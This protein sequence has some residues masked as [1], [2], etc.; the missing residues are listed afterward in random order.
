MG[1][2]PRM[3]GSSVQ[4]SRPEQRIITL[5]PNAPAAA[6]VLL[7]K[8]RGRSATYCPPTSRAATISFGLPAPHQPHGDHHCRARFRI[9]DA[10]PALPPGTP[11]RCARHLHSLCRR[12]PAQASLLFLFMSAQSASGLL[13]IPS[14]HCHG[15][16]TT[17][18]TN[19]PN[20]TPT[21]TSW[22]QLQLARAAKGVLQGA[23]T[24]VP[25]RHARPASG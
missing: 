23:A 15:V 10:A 14:C 7:W 4:S 17:S 9:L 11:P 12:R 13:E 24:H 20:P 1:M 2:S 21:P 25:R 3:L 16:A 22:R 5:C 8:H 19:H 18:S 6:D